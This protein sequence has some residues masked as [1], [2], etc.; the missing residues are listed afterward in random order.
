MSYITLPPLYAL[1]PVNMAIL[2]LAPIKSAKKSIYECTL[3]PK[4]FNHRSS[5]SRHFLNHT[6]EIRFNCGVCKKGFNRKDSLIQHRKSKKCIFRTQ[7]YNVRGIQK[8]II[9]DK[10]F[11]KQFSSQVISTSTIDERMNITWL[12]TN[13][14]GPTHILRDID[15][16]KTFRNQFYF[17]K[18][19]N[20]TEKINK[21]I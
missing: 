15:N 20:T 18:F 6:G 2:S 11:S 14:S 16:Y 4:E 12:L 5:L 13:T 19:S 8:N 7:N 3:C 9:N 21:N 10:K 1:P 17:I